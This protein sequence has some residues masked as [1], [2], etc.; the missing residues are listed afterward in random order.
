[1]KALLGRLLLAAFFVSAG[2]GAQTY[3]NHSIRLIVPFAPGGGSDAITRLIA[4]KMTP[5]LGQAV[6][7]ENKA[8]AS[9]LIGVD[10]VAKAAPDGYTLIMANSSVTSNPWLYKLPYDTQKDLLPV[11]MLA[12]SPQAL[13]ANPKAPFNSMS[14]LITY[15]KANPGHATIGTAGAGQISH[16]AA[17]LLAHEAGIEVLMVHYKGT[18]NSLADLLGGQ[19]MMSFGTAPGFIPHIKAKT[20]KPLAVAG[21]KRLPALPDVPTVAET[22]PGF[23]MMNWFGIFA[24]AGTPK[25]VVD[26]LYAVIRKALDDPAVQARLEEEGYEVV[27]STPAEF[28]G[29]FNSE[30]THWQEVVKKYDI[31]IN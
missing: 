9:G 23:E 8:G 12:R 5:Q 29:V 10:T 4:E 17:E 6:V 28:S 3:P 27:G 21:P 15:A 20:L 26:K 13:V 2:A 24:P 30:L 1:M 11:T 22:L 7:V 25:P 31:K 14:E 19:I 18:G 16:L